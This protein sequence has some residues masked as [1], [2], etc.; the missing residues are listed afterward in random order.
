MSYRADNES[1]NQ[2]FI[3]LYQEE[4]MGDTYA[5]FVIVPL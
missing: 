3:S 2:A 1:L 5:D 4:E